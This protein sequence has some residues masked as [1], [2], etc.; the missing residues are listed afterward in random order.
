MIFMYLL[1]IYFVVLV[2][3]YVVLGFD[4]VFVL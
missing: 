4:M 2:V 1:L 3:I